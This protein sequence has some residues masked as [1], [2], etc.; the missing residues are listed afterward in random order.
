MGEVWAPN[1]PGY[2]GSTGRASLSTF[3]DAA[4]TVYRELEREAAGRPIIVTGNS[5]GTSTALHLAATNE[6]VA[7]LV[8]RNP[9]PLRE[10]IAWRFG[11]KTLGMGP[12]LVGSRIPPQLDSI[13]NAARVRFPAVF[14]MSLADRIVPVPLQRRIIDAYAGPKRVVELA[15]AD[16]AFELTDDQQREYAA[17]LR[18]LREQ[19]QS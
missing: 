11:W 9:P 3:A 10:L 14:V 7:A 1:P 15:G 4:Q 16:H 13:A 6:S 8:L 19:M 17:A 5:L 12:L 2:G 18:W